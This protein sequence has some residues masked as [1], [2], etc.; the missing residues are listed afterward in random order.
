MLL[1][2]YCRVV[3]SR[4]YKILPLQLLYKAAL[5]Y[6]ELEK[7]SL[8]IVCKQSY[9]RLNLTKLDRK[10]NIRDTENYFG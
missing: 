5:F 2:L 7:L 6:F 10:T 3:E 9:S 4:R 8:I 1:L